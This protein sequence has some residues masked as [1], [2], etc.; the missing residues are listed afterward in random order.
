[1]CDLAPERVRLDVVRADDLAAD[2]DDRDP[3]PVPRLQLVVA[4]DVH[5]A[6]LEAQLVLELAE[7]RPRELAQVASLRAVKSDLY[8]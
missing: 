6:Q 7:P 5:F 8:G 4:G 1:L 2:L 3:L